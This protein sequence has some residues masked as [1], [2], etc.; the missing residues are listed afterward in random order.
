MDGN[1]FNLWRLQTK[2]KERLIRDYLFAD[3]AAIVART[4]T[5][6]AHHILLCG[7]LTAVWP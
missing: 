5:I 4:V 3:D 1:L 2:T 7:C 6:E